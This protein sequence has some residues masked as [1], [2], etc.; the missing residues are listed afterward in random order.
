MYC[1]CLLLITLGGEQ[2]EKCKIREGRGE[3]QGFPAIDYSGYRGRTAVARGSHEKKQRS[4]DPLPHHPRLHPQAAA[5]AAAE[6]NHDGR[7][8]GGTWYG[9]A[10]GRPLNARDPDAPSPAARPAFPRGAFPASAPPCE[11]V[12]RAVLSW[13]EH[14]RGQSQAAPGDHLLPPPR[15]HPAPA[16]S[17]SD[18]LAPR[19]TQDPSG[20]HSFHRGNN[21]RP[22]RRRERVN[23]EDQ[24]EEKK[25]IVLIAITS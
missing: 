17:G 23:G 12:G 8:R 18:S 4:H 9:V 24:W 21:S 25:I 5:S 1:Q 10:V 6:E 7:G 19:E 16:L 20:S 3:V 22:G 13:R 2:R 14:R 11:V 15:P